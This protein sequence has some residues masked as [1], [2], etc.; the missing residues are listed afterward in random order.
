MTLFDNIF[1]NPT[2]YAIIIYFISANDV[3]FNI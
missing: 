2:F 3:Q 1:F